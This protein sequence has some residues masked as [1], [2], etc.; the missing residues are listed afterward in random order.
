MPG[1]G[2]WPRHKGQFLI[3]KRFS[4]I[5]A[6]L[7]VFESTSIEHGEG[8]LFKLVAPL[9]YPARVFLALPAKS[10]RNPHTTSSLPSTAIRFA[11]NAGTVRSNLRTKKTEKSVRLIDGKI[12]NGVRLI[13]THTGPGKLELRGVTRGKAVTSQSSLKIIHSGVPT[14]KPSPRP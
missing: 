14:N 7:S 12:E 8:D 6:T 1:L 11:T 13:D 3:R 2:F 4:A 10:T 5:L 9:R